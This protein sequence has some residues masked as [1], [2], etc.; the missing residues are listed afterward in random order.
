MKP[1][2]EFYQLAKAIQENY[3]CLACFTRYKKVDEE[4]TCPNCK[5][6]RREQ[7]AEYANTPVCEKCGTPLAYV[8]AENI[9]VCPKCLEEGRE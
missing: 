7:V 3:T 1:G 2:D 6:T 8:W 5:L 4:A 9:W